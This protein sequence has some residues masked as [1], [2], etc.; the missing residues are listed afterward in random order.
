MSEKFVAF[1]ASDIQTLFFGVSIK[2]CKCKIFVFF[3]F[4]ASASGSCRV[5]GYF[6]RKQSFVFAICDDDATR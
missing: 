4:F 2:I 3:I 6:E 1:V 5:V